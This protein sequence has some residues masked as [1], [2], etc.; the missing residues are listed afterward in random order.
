MQAEVERYRA[1]ALAKIDQ[2]ACVARGG[3][4][5]SF[6]MF[7]T[8]VCAVP[9]ADGGKPC[10]DSSECLGKCVLGLESDVPVGPARTGECQ[11]DDHL[12]GCWAEIRSGVVGEGLCVD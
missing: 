12:D 11:L 2:P 3:R 5:R 1:E 9:F 10:S 6:G 4:I 8:P 7:G